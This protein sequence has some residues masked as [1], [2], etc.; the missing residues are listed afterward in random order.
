MVKDSR[1]LVESISKYGIDALYRYLDAHPPME[2]R[3]L[4]S[5]YMSEWILEDI[6]VQQRIKQGYMVEITKIQSKR[7]LT[8]EDKIMVNVYRSK[9]GLPLIYKAK[10]V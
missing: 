5:K 1:I 4:E 6:G 9:L 7:P 2:F 10:E 8:V 3:S